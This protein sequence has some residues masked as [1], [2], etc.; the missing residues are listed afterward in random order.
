[1]Y[2][3]KVANDFH[4]YHITRKESIWLIWDYCVLGNIAHIPVLMLLC[5]FS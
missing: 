4:G 5:S 3:I 1:M 2:S